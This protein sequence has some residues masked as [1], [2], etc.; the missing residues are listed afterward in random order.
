MKVGRLS[1]EEW[2]FIDEN[3]DG[4]PASA[5]AHHLDRSVESIE[6]H[7]AKIGK[8]P[9]KTQNFVVQAE[10]DIKSR[11]YWREIRSQFS[12]DEIELFLSLWTEI[13]AQFRKDVLPT[14]ELQIIDLIKLE[15]LMNRDLREQNETMESVR[16]Y[17]AECDAEKAKPPGEKDAERIFVLERQI[18]SL[19]A[20]REAL[21]RD[22][23]DLHSKKASLNKDLKATREQRIEK[24]ENNRET[25]AA[26]VT[27]ILRDPDFFEEEGKLIE[28]MRLAMDQEKARL[29]DYHT[30]EDG[31]IDQPFLTPDTVK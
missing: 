12:A 28:K 29:S 3:A 23:K 30:Y 4:L 21:A 15:I 8:T 18:A 1:K 22:Y 6:R 5:I 9:D 31:T 11:A 16:R 13:V 27:R 24:L 19:R 2:K 7:L 25:L 14:E 10:Y 17:E 26:L 20:G